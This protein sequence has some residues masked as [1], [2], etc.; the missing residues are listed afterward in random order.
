MKQMSFIVTIIIF[1]TDNG[2]QQLRYNSG[3]RGKKGGVYNGGIKVP[4]FM[5]VPKKFQELKKVKNLSAHIDVL[6]TITE[7]CG[8]DLPKN[9]TID[10]R[11]L[12]PNMKGEKGED[13]FLFS[14]Y[15]Y[16]IFYPPLPPLKPL[17]T[18]DQQHLLE[19]VWV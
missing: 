15:V 6:P 10:G 11:S 19:S 8:L 17:D 13:R 12:V 3:L 5:K 2:P 16:L 18:F 7:L 4:F 14:Y 9:I 1:M